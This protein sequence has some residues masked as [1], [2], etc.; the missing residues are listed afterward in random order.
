MKKHN[1][2][3]IDDDESLRKVISHNL[4]SE[5]YKVASARGGREGIDLFKKEE[6]DLVVTDLKMSDLDGMEVLREVKRL[7]K[8]AL[9]IMITAY[10]TIE[11]AVEALKAGAYDY[12]TKPFNRDELKIAVEKALRIKSLEKENLK[13]KSELN[14]K[15]RFDNII[16][17][18][19]KMAD[20]LQLI[21]RVSKTDSTVLLLGE[22]GTGKELI[23]RAVH[24]NSSRNDKPLVIVNCAAIP[25]DL[26]ESELFGHQKGSFTGAL[27]DKAGKFEH[28]NGGTIFL[29]EIGDLKLELQAKLLRVLQEKTIDKVGGVDPIEVDVRVIAAT[30]QNL[31]RQI[32]DGAFREDLYYRLSVIP[33]KIPSL[34]ERRDDIFLLIEHFLKV[35]KTPPNVKFSP[36]AIKVME[37]CIWKGNVREL[38]NVIE[39]ALLLRKGDVISPDDLPEEIRFSSAITGSFIRELPEE[40]ISLVDIEK[41]LLIKALEKNNWNQSKTASF[42]SITRATLIYRMEKY[43][44]RRL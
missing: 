6:F 24:C 29:D 22:S 2:L 43:N 17:V 19:S 28:A 30:N 34:R 16:G 8:D 7:N 36:E 32:E 1:I 14:E 33:V 3:L 31:R 25:E 13:L 9:V 27:G 42:L 44:L 37:N 5:G 23:A 41:E 26:M 20:V 15:F 18:S 11:K 35:F 21:K 40:G 10:G 39:R 38:G 4:T 12:V